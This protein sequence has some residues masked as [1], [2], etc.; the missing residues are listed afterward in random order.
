[1][2]LRS[3]G[4]YG[5]KGG[6]PAKGRWGLRLLLLSLRVEHQERSH[7]FLYGFGGDH[8]LSHVGPGG[9]V[10]HHIPHE[11]FQDRLEA[12]GTRTALQRLLSDGLDRRRTAGM[13]L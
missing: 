6:N 8:Y 10:E 5:M 1:M 3:R 7:A 13:L 9:N 12:P 11:L 4:A 2:R